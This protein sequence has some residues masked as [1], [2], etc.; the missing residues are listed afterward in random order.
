VAPGSAELRRRQLFCRRKNLFK[1]LASGTYVDYAY[2]CVVC[3]CSCTRGAAV[4]LGVGQA[5]GGPGAA[6]SLEKLQKMHL[7]PKWHERLSNTSSN[8]NF[9]I[10]FRVARWFVFK[11][12]NPNL[13]KFWRILQWKMMVYFMGTWSISPSFVI[14]YGHLESC[15]VIWYIFSRFGILYQDKSGN[16]DSS[17]AQEKA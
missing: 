15:V 14:F 9:C 2:T 8:T 1:K 6:G 11:T 13:V 17:L 12:K 10:F 4:V 16:P 3:R 5:A 7:L